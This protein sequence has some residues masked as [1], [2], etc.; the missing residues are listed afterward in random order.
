M[1]GILAIFSALDLA[2]LAIFLTAWA[3]YEAFVA[4]ATRRGRNLPA[5]MQ[6]WRERWMA[7]AVDRDNRILD[8]QILQS[9]TGNSAF[10]AST[11]IFVIGGLAAVLGAAADVV[12][13]L[14]GFDYFAVTSQNR[15]GFKVALMI[16]IF[17][18]AFF[19]LA[20]SMRL[21]N[22][23]GVV[24]GA[25]PQPGTGDPAMA[26][27]RAAV[28]ARLVTLA[29][30]HYNGGMHSY[31]FGLAACAWFLHPA[32]LIAATAWVVAILYRR[33]FRS[34]AHVALAIEDFG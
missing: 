31:Y 25:I 2:A 14:N 11:A 21:H 4:R 34:R 16:L 15:F 9:L 24:L 19:R 20:W 22:N 18:H 5:R 6:V 26:R 23:A 10:L 1:D 7:S 29:A 3:G 27:S 12:A 32:G 17:M 33:E 13:V 30:R 28:A 8:V